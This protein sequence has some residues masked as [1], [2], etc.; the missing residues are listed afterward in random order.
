MIRIMN[1]LSIDMI[2]ID[3]GTFIMGE[4][5]SQKKIEIKEDFELG[6]YPITIAEYMHFAKEYGEHLPKWDEELLDENAPI[7]SISW[8][9][10]VSYCNWLNKKQKKYF[11]RLPTEAEWEYSCRAGT[12]SKWSFGDDEKELG[13]YAWYNKNSEGKTHPVGLKKSNPWGLYDM[14]GNV[15]E[16][17]EDWYNS[18]KKDKVLR[19]GSWSNVDSVTRS[20][21]RFW[22]NPSNSFSYVGFRLLRTLS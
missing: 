2:K 6:K 20:A 1:S 16:I 4:G 14:H 3:K 11:Y 7:I 18:D 19:G 10:A 17:C 15:W 13:Q 5:D 12:T 21:V 22:N 8:Y 9:N